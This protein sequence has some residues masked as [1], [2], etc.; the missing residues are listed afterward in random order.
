MDTFLGTYFATLIAA[1]Y[2]VLWTV[3]YCS[4]NLIE[5]LRA[6]SQP[7]GAPADLALFSFYQ[8]RSGFLGPVSALLK[9]RWALA[10]VAF[11]ALLTNLLPAFASESTYVNTNWNCPN[12]DVTNKHNPCPPT[13]FVDPG[14]LRVLQA[15]LV[16]AVLVAFWL[17]YLQFVDKSYIPDDPRSL[18]TIT[19]LT[20]HPDLIDDF[21]RV[22]PNATISEMKRMFRGRKYRLELYR[23]ENG[24]DCYGIRPTIEGTD[25][26]YMALS[27]GR[28]SRYPTPDDA[29]QTT[30]AQMPR[31]RR[32]WLMDIVLVIL[33]IGLF[34]LVLAYLRDNNY[35]DGFNT[36]FNSDTF[37]P[38]FILTLSGTA[39]ATL[40]KSAE[41]CECNLTI[42][43]PVLVL[44][45]CAASVV[46]APWNRLATRPSCADDT[47]LFNPSITPIS[48]TFRAIRHGYYS[49]G[50]I[51]MITLLADVGLNTVIGG[52]AYTTGQTK[53]ALP[54]IALQREV[55]KTSQSNSTS[56][57]TSR[58]SSWA[59]CWSWLSC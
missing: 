32:I 16:F 27:N 36:F 3:V 2:R 39:I 15:L 42:S 1:L 47:I 53:R 44:T 8:S 54:C 17:V 34:G 55:A 13:I 48:S 33:I 20:Q 23:S 40:W 24:T 30:G 6:L 7:N 4:F 49:V 51:A 43:L 38:R 46:N 59:S 41:Q 25:F 11:T 57:P 35:D 50:A 37:G 18:A 52:V 28:P 26:K 14:A 29:I 19:T 22:P 45:K 10:L 56:R 12:P 9:R 31:T 58:L 5:P 21:N